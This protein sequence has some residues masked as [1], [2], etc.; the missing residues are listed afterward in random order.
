MLDLFDVKRFYSL[1][2]LAKSNVCL[3]SAQIYL[4]FRVIVVTLIIIPS[5][6]VDYIFLVRLLYG[7]LLE[8]S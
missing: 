2:E 3:E 6:N 5:R 8:Q 1:V 7:N 4:L